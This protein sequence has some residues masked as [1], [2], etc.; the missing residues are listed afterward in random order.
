MLRR[1]NELAALMEALESLPEG[2]PLKDDAAY[3]AVKA[4][5]YVRVRKIISITRQERAAGSTAAISH[6]E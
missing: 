5:K 3:Q 2:N 4:H 1:I 6:R